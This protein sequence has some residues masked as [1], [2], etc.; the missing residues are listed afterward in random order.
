ME[1][2]QVPGATSK[3]YGP[4]MLLSTL[5]C[6]DVDLDSVLMAEWWQ[7]NGFAKVMHPISLNN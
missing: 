3:L 2:P 5:V 1:T 6:G 4:G 7:K